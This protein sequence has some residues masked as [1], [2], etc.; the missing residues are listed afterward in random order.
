[1]KKGGKNFVR[2]PATPRVVLGTILGLVFF[3]E[4]L[5]EGPEGA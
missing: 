5:P 2:T 3:M 1:M 4:Q